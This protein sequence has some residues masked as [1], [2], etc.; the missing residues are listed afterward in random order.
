MVFK[1]FEENK[2]KQEINCVIVEDAELKI[3][4][5]II[6]KYTR[7]FRKKSNN[8][9]F[10]H[11]FKDKDNISKKNTQPPIITIV[12]GMSIKDRIK[13]FS[14]ELIRRQ[15]ENKILPGRLKIPEIFLKGEKEAKDKKEKEQKEKGKGKG[16]DKK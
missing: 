16:K 6:R 12:P 1:N 14:G 7:F 11:E 5:K 2:K 3:F 10:R 13:I 4:V 8:I 15:L 9:H